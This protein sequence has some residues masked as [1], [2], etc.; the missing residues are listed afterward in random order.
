MRHSQDEVERFMERKEFNI[1]KLIDTIEDSQE[2][3][4]PKNDDREVDLSDYRQAK[5]E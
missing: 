5:E 2:V 4:I 1:P 3:I